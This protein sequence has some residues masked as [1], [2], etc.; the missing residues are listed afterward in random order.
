MIM[1]FKAVVEF[2]YHSII[3][4]GRTIAAITADITCD[5]QCIHANSGVPENTQSSNAY[6]QHLMDTIAEEQSVST[7]FEGGTVRITYFRRGQQSA[8][9]AVC[10]AGAADENDL[11]SESQQISHV[12]HA[13]ICKASLIDKGLG[14]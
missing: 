3:I 14:I 10:S 1:I 6:R 8:I 4:G 5:G 2:N 7:T 13:C 9:A 11:C 12:L